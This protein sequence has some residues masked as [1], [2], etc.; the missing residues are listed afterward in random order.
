[1]CSSHPRGSAISP[2]GIHG[3]ISVMITL[4]FAYFLIKGIKLISIIAKLLQLAT[5]SFRMTV[6]ISSD[7]ETHCTDEETDGPFNPGKSRNALLHMLLVCI[8]SHQ[9]SVLKYK[10]L[11]LDQ[12]DSIYVNKDVRICSYFSKPGG[13]HEQNCLGNAVSVDY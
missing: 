4:R 10:F 2:Q 8:N 3:Y 1:M 7:N 6:R 5:C 9:K 12:P 11:I 13:V